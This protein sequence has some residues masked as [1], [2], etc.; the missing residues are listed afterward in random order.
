MSAIQN[1]ATGFDVGDP[2]RIPLDPDRLPQQAAI[3]AA[4]KSLILSASGWRKVF[5]LHR[6]GDPVAPWA[7][8]RAGSDPSEDSLS[9]AVSDADLV[10][11]GAMAL[12]FGEYLRGKP[13]GSGEPGKPGAVLLGIDSR[14]TGRALGDIF[15]RILTALDIEV[16]YLFIVAAPEI[17]AYAGYAAA[18]PEGHPEKA[19]AFAYISASHNPPGHNGVKF[20]AGSGGVLSGAEIAPLID[21]Y[22]ALIASPDTPGRIAGLLRAA[23]RTAVRRIFT[24]TT[25]WK[26]LA[27]SS[28]TLFSHLVVTGKDS[29]EGQDALLDE[30]EE[31]CRERPIGVVADLNGSARCLSLDADWLGALGVRVRM[32]GDRVGEFSHRIVPEGISLNAC[33]AELEAAHRDSPEFELGYSPDC[34]GDRGNLV[35]FDRSAP[36][37]GAARILEA[38]EVFALCCVAELASLARDGAFSGGSGGSAGS[39]VAIA[40]NDGTSMRIEAI[41]AAFGARVFRAETG[42]ANVVGLAERLRGEGWIVRILGEGSNG[43]NITHPARVRDPLATLGAILKLLRLRDGRGGPGLFRIWL[44]ASGQAARYRPD[45]DLPEVIGSLPAWISTSVFE[46]RAGL[47]VASEDK[48]A[49]K[50]R[51]RAVFLEEWEFRK[52]ELASKWGIAGWSA[53]AS[54]GSGERDIGDAFEASGSGGLRIVFSGQDGAR[55]AFLWMRGSGTEPVFRIMADIAGG[56]ARDEEYFLDWHASMVKRADACT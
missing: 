18:L 13:R 46:P 4:A 26:R 35:W 34:D 22:R 43:G 8:V 1:P 42:E 37:G 51:Y 2:D 25:R 32:I 29:R 17:M 50:R 6:K 9:A 27:L 31:S 16:R 55:K 21:A 23:D 45:F 41:A 30:L 11:A 36:N 20:G 47:A 38:Q 40:V 24:E 53:F 10:L 52:A 5:A 14:P 48:V 49:L 56:G 12:A 28:Y 33:R 39:R 54:N 15:C 7:R 3:A 44:E 19:D